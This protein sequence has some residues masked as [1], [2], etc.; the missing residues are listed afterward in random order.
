VV[1]EEEVVCTVQGAENKKAGE[2]K[3]GR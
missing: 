1:K 2:R 3:A